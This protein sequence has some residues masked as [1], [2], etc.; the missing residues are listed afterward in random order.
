M[1]FTEEIPLKGELTISDTL[2][3]TLVKDNIIVQQGRYGILQG[4]AQSITTSP[5][6]SLQYGSG[7]TSDAA[8]L[9]PL[10]AQITQ[11]SLN[12]YQGTLYTTVYNLSPTSPAITF[13][14]S[15]NQSDGN[16]LAISEAGLFTQSGLLFNYI[17]FPAIWKIQEFGLNFTWNIGF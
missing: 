2:G 7:G 4:L 16:G 11:E 1:L 17:T 15:M 5:I 6:T 12:A 9:Y 10:P 14:A 3:N 13:S 8:G